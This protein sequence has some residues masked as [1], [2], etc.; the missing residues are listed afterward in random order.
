MTIASLAALAA[1]MG[2]QTTPFLLAAFDASHGEAS[3]STRGLFGSALFVGFWLGSVCGGPLADAIGPGRT[4]LAMVALG[5]LAGAAPAA[6][7]AFVPLVAIV[8]RGVVGFC[9][10]IVYQAAN[11][12]IAEGVPT[13][14]RG[15]Y[16]SLLHAAIAVGNL[17][18]S[19]I[20]VF[21]ARDDWRTLL[22]T[23]AAPALAVS[24]ASAHYVLAHESPRWLLVARGPTAAADLLRRL[25]REN[26]G[27]ALADG[28][29]P[30]L[31]RAS[32]GNQLLGESSPGPSPTALAYRGGGGS[33]S[34]GSG[35]EPLA[36]RISQLASRRL[37]KL[38]AVACSVAFCH[39]FAT[40]G[41]DL[42]LGT[43]MEQV[44]QRSLSRSV[45]VAAAVGK[46]IGDFVTAVATN[47][48]GRLRC[49]RASFIAA[50]AATVLLSFARG[51]RMLMLF[52][53]L[54]GAASDMV[55]CNLYIY[56]AE[57]YPSTIRATAFGL[58][59]GIG[60]FGGVVSTGLGDLNGSIERS[61][62]VYGASSAVGAL[63]VSLFT[64]ETSHRP[65]ADRSI[66]L[67][68]PSSS[69]SASSQE[70]LA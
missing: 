20:A 33:S 51:A 9:A 68:R 32:E 27:S 3:V 58:V 47:R 62:V 70:T 12:W 26:G 46:L 39:N 34:S 59:M 6:C 44:G 43:Y 1:A 7:S 69:C 16:L 13:A 2:T 64:L 42:W 45:Y 48:L 24:A 29:P 23:M 61:F 5:A 66:E 30:P 41:V 52:A 55:W 35:G 11:S 65:L 57:I 63:L 28:L 49:L 67:S 31:P 37:L 18:A 25:E 8:F 50:A 36:K 38:H 22:L 15:A 56:L 19:A 53:A 21:V 14:V 60:R 10:V 4:M 17:T 40:K 54:Q